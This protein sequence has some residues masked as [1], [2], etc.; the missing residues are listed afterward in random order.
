V[1]RRQCIPATLAPGDNPERA[2]PAQ[3]T[4]A[5]QLSL[6]EFMGSRSGRSKAFPRTSIGRFGYRRAPDARAPSLTG[7]FRWQ[8]SIPKEPRVNSLMKPSRN[9]IFP[10]QVTLNVSLMGPIVRREPPVTLNR[11]RPQIFL[12]W[13]TLFSWDEFPLSCAR[14]KSPPAGVS[15]HRYFP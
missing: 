3:F 9:W 5:P 10:C 11:C 13:G 6:E 7:D 14:G 15:P 8:I 4:G 1:G 2:D 12:R